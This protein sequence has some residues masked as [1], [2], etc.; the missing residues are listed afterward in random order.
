MITRVADIASE[1]YE[2]AFDAFGKAKKWERAQVDKGKR[3]ERA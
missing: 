2:G 3:E 1:V